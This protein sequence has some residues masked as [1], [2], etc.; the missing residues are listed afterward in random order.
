[1][2]SNLSSLN[3]AYSKMDY[4][5]ILIQSEYVIKTSHSQEEIS[6]CYLLLGKTYNKLERK[7]EAI[8]YLKKSI[9]VNDNFDAHYALGTIYINNKKYYKG[10]EEYLKCASKNINYFKIHEALFLAL[11]YLNRFPEAYLELSFVLIHQSKIESHPLIT[12]LSLYNM[13]LL[14]ILGQYQKV[15]KLIEKFSEQNKKNEKIIKQKVVA[16]IGLKKYS[17]CFPYVENNKNLY[18]Y[19]ALVLYKTNKLKEALMVFVENKNTDNYMDHY[20]KG[21]ILKKKKTNSD[22]IIMNYQKTVKINPRFMKGYIAI[23]EEYINNK[24]YI[25]AI[26]SIDSAVFN[27]D[28]EHEK[29]YFLYLFL[30]KCEVF[31]YLNK[32]DEAKKEYEEIT[33]ILQNEK[34]LF[35]QYREGEMIKVLIKYFKLYY[36][37]SG[38]KENMLKVSKHYLGN[39]GFGT[40]FSGKLKKDNKE[41]KVAIKR[42]EFNINDTTDTTKSKY[43]KLR[44]LIVIFRELSVMRIFQTE[45]NGKCQPNCECRSY[46]LDV[47]TIF[48]I[49]SQFY[50]ITPLC[51]G[52]DL[53]NLLYTPSI[54]IPIKNRLYILLQIAKA[55][56]HMHSYKEPYIHR[57]VKSMNI[58]LEEKY[59]RYQL[60]KVKL[61]DFGLTKQQDNNI[62]DLYSTLQFSPPELLKKKE[63]DQS[64]DVYS[65]GI[66][67]WEVFTRKLPFFNM[68]KIEICKLIEQGEH[69]SENEF[70]KT[71]P[72]DIIELYLK[73]VNKDKKS[74]PS[75]DEAIQVIQSEF[76]LYIKEK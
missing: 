49:D 56:Y 29:K 44:Q 24:E 4:N 6:E 63:F 14:N 30:L 12:Q 57:D 45:P 64:V 74:R 46:L 62:Y 23:V 21:K 15:L 61:I 50:L 47:I 70:E 11:Y 69:P 19:K 28:I 34:S 53:S 41:I 58:L 39:G 3:D 55:L 37:K 36:I 17:E 27:F 67:I 9:E 54:K 72:K 35:Y 68:D 10:Y 43:S 13:E 75:I 5:R 20:L 8:F 22:S 26:N 65:F 48:Y 51:K 66:L 2:N 33:N 71:T 25:A 73:C 32:E 7:D 60:T 59:D 18:Y 16:L 1:M 52:K 31:M 38:F 42:Y 40:V 76:D